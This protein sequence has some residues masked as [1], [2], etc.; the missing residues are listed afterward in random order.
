MFIMP[1]PSLVTYSFHPLTIV[2]C[3]SLN[4]LFIFIA[5]S[6]TDKNGPVLGLRKLEC[7]TV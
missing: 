3:K 7:L 4:N 6:C 2:S 5:L 1:E